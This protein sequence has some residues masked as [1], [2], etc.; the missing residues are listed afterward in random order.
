MPNH[1]V[2]KDEALGVFEVLEELGDLFVVRVRVCACVCVRVCVCVC[3]C[4]CVR[5]SGS[6]VGGQRRAS[7]PSAAPF[8]CLTFQSDTC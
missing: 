5:F 7:W 6:C 4:V 8:G 2:F 3:V 1:V